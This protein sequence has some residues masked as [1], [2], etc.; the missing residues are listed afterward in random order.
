M[1]TTP[2]RPYLER[3]TS[4]MWQTKATHV[5]TLRLAC[6]GGGGV[7]TRVWHIQIVVFA[8]EL[9]SEGECMVCQH[10]IYMWVVGRIKSSGGGG[11][12]LM[13]VFWCMANQKML[14][15]GALPLL[16]QFSLFVGHSIAAWACLP[17]LSSNLIPPPPRR[18]PH[19]PQRCGANPI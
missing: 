13:P 9:Y 15:R 3:S 18:P 10:D 19:G 5:V 14:C 17:T 7:C 11:S 16:F 2:P 4:M 6:V 12:F 1:H 8:Q